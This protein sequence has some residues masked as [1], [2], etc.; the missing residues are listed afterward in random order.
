MAKFDIFAR[1]N[2][3]Q[4]LQLLDI[5]NENDLADDVLKA[6][7][8]YEPILKQLGI[9]DELQQYQQVCLYVYLAKKK[10]SEKVNE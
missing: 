1:Q 9:L 8:K 5:I 7:E 6:K 3:K 10:K 2:N 4:L